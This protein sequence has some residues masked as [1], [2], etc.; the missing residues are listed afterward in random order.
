MEESESVR[1]LGAG[2]EERRWRV[3]EKMDGGEALATLHHFYAPSLGP[4]LLPVAP[5]PRHLPTITCN[6]DIPM[7]GTVRTTT[8]PPR[9]GAGTGTGTGTGLAPRLWRCFRY[10]QPASPFLRPLCEPLRLQTN[11][12]TKYALASPRL[13]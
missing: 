8:T 3:V 7:S 11:T 5:E 10:R 13:A 12:I 4:R 1:G 6:L 9:S 2:A